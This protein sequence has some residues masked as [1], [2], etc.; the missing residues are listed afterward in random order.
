MTYKR[1]EKGMGK[2]KGIIVVKV[3]TAVL[4]RHLSGEKAKTGRLACRTGR[5]AYRTG[6]L[7]SAFIK[8]LTRQI[9]NLKKKGFRVIL[10][11]SGAIGAG[12][13]AIGLNRRPDDLNKLQACAAIGQGKLMKLYEE[14]F[15]FHGKHAAQILLTREDFSSKKRILMAKHTIMSL[16]DD[17]NAV[18][19]INENDT[20]ATEEIRFGD[21]DTLSALVAKFV[22]A[23]MLVMLTDV[24]GLYEPIIKHVIPFVEK[25]DKKIEKMAQPSLSILGKGGMYS[26]IEAAKIATKAGIISV[27]ANGRAKDVLIRIAGKRPVGTLFLPIEKK[28]R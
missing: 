15:R 24:D 27:I 1:E 13:E 23:Y 10:V 11:S 3:G 17:F 7:D 28:R 20:I 18:P 6:R 12:M 14:N 9:C 19:V 2:G 21:N 22:G 16:L 25:I 5:P 8:E 4:G 26:K